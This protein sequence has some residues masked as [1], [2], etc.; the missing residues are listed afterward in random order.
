[1]KIKKLMINIHLYPS[2]FS[3]ET[4][5]VKQA[6]FLQKNYTFKKIYLLGLGNKKSFKIDKNIEVKLFSKKKNIKNLF[7]KIF[8]FIYY[9]YK[10]IFFFKKKIYI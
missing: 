2:D 1:M 5:I 8:L 6:K 3:F 9:Y 7:Y 4:R 10:V